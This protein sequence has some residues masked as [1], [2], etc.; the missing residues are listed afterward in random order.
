MKPKLSVNR[1]FPGLRSYQFEDAD[2]FYGRDDQIFGLYRLFDHS[3]FIA[4]VGGSGSGKSSLVRAGLLPFLAKES[5]E[6]TGRTWKMVQMH[7]GDSPIG[8]LATAIAGQLSAND[9][10]SIASARREHIRFA[11]QR[12]SYGIAAALREIEGLG[13][14]S[15]VIV[16]DQFEELFRYLTNQQGDTPSGE[17]QRKDEATHFVQ[18]LL[19]ASR[20]R[21]LNV[22]VLLTMRSDFIGDCA[23]FRGLPEAI[24]TSQFLV[25]S[26]TR[27][28][29]EEAIR[30]PIEEKAKASIEPALVERLL[31]DTGDDIDQLP[32]LQHTLLRLWEQAGRRC[33]LN[34][35]RQ[36]TMD[37]YKEIGGMSGAL[38]K[39]AEEVLDSLNGL[40]LTVEQVFRAL[41][42]IDAE[43]RII[44][45]ARLFR[46][47]RGETGMPD[48]DLRTVIDRLREDDCSFLT[49]S[50]SEVATLAD[51][52]RIDVG[53]EALLRGWDRVSAD[54]RTGAPQ[55]G[56]LRQEVR[57]G[58]I[59]R[60]LLA[61]ADSKS[62]RIP[63]DIVE[64][65]W[66]WW[67]ERPRTEDWCKRYGG[68]RE[69]VERLFQRSL[70]WLKTER[71]LEQQRAQEAAERQRIE[72]EAATARRTAF[73]VSCL[74][75]LALIL[76]AVSVWQWNVA[77]QER[78]QATQNFN[79]S[80]TL[81]GT[82]LS[83]IQEGL[84][85]GQITVTQA[86]QMLASAE[87]IWGQFKAID[88]SPASLASQAQ[89]Y[90]TF[91]DTYAA[92]TD[93]DSAL[94]YAENA[95]TITQKLVTENPTDTNYEILLF[96]AD[97]NRGDAEAFV[98]TAE[99]AMRDYQAALS[100]VQTL[101]DD[102]PTNLRWKQNIAFILNK[103]G[104][105]YGQEGRTDLALQSY[106]SA[107]TINQN[108]ATASPGDDN[109][110]RDWATALSRV[111]DAELDTNLPNALAKYQQALQIREMLASKYPTDTGMQSNLASTHN[112]IGGVFLREKNYVDALA[113][114]NTALEIRK[115]LV[116]ANSSNATWQNYLAAQYSAIGDMLAKEGD[117]PGAATNYQS[118]LTN[119]LN[120]SNRD[121]ANST[122]LRALADAYTKV[123]GAFFNQQSL[124]DALTYY[125]SA[126]PQRIKI[127]AKY[128]FNVAR[129]NELINV[130]VAI[131][132]IYEQQNDPKETTTQF[133]NALNVVQAFRR[134]NP[135]N[136]ALAK[137]GDSLMAKL[138]NTI[139]NTNVLGLPQ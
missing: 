61:R 76:G 36:L 71:E 8:N 6:P 68:G 21:A 88:Q 90:L 13:D 64:D 136:N 85:T 28:Q 96:K 26:L 121:P 83:R 80:I 1:P 86:Q 15:I 102:N 42:E 117:Y 107:L 84:D 30:R 79:A 66:K 99:A 11:L 78:N 22:Y 109:M 89:L 46:E 129:Q 101:S 51:E 24:S 120:V 81:V 39:H 126:L 31:N 48:G 41:A 114:Y 103:I 123:A 69:D 139:S 113:Q 19:G 4:V 118:A 97:Y 93:N 133:Q 70:N 52:T 112:S 27:D 17:A 87:T 115:E 56:W 75:I 3:R 5:R 74:A 137:V 7:P 92:L 60:S 35:T 45:R 44:R 138:S 116:S 122:K 2:Y 23:K 111:A 91:A 10:A 34:T 16:V 98:S 50:K 25:P 125:N 95:Q 20:D 134:S 47:L 128:P 58:R 119:R 29:R 82:L 12:S 33:G 53:H 106:Q 73:V 32:V 104:D 135:S 77:D 55:L 110:Q 40:L 124:T 131:G 38:S 94:K 105:T 43:G 57:D 72:R 14:T 18:L 37:D 108:L 59:Y 130:Y 67:N 65:R 127:A 62:D 63:A 54:T 49:P 132:N 100:I 9:D